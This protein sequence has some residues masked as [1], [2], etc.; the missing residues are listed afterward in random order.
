MAM[1]K[2]GAFIF[3]IDGTLVD[4]MDAHTQAWLRFLEQ[5]GARLDSPDA[6]R[7]LVGRTTRDIL[8]QVFGE[9]LSEA[10]IADLT[11]QKESLYRQLYLPALEPLPGLLDF[12]EQARALGIPL[13]V[14]SSAHKPNIDYTLDGLGIRAYFQEIIGE[15]QVAHPKPDPEIYLTT[16]AR[17]GT[18]PQC[19][20]VFED[21]AVGIRAALGAGARVIGVATTLEAEALRRDF[22]LEAVIRD[23]TE[24]EPGR[25]IA[26]LFGLS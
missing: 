15:E 24:V 3:D 13:A 4:S 26:S 1:D 18:S 14:A 21:S 11:E 8:I 25:L 9:G 10:E 12:L 2:P 16:A 23:Y 6:R 22:P 20:I 19:C 7:L 5:K 17:L